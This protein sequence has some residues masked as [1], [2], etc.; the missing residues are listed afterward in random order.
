M[1]LRGWGQYVKLNIKISKFQKKSVNN[2]PFQ[3]LH[4]L[5]SDFPEI[6]DDN[7]EIKKNQ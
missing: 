2:T 1:V 7:Y 5:T 6:E 3:F 4:D